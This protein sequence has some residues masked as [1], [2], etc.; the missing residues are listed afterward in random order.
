MESLFFRS[1]CLPS[2]ISVF[3]TCFQS[4]ILKVYKAPNTI[5]KYGE[6]Y[7]GKKAASLMIRVLIHI[8][9]STAL[10][11]F[12]IRFFFYFGKWLNFKQHKSHFL[13]EFVLL[14]TLFACGLLTRYYHSKTAQYVLW[15][16]LPVP[17][18]STLCCKKATWLNC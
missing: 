2:V 16:L 10:I 11:L 5:S 15:K 7:R 14:S 6:I 13:R 3:S 8:G 17:L 4:H 9:T 1:D 12:G 18:I